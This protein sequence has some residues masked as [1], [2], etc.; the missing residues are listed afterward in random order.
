[1]FWAAGVGACL[2]ALSF[3]AEGIDARLLTSERRELQ[4]EGKVIV[5]L[6]QNLHYSTRQFH[7]I[8]AK[9]IV[10]QFARRNDPERL[11]FSAEDMAFLQRRFG[12]S[13]KTVYLLKG[14]VQPA[15]EMFDLYRE[16]ARGRLAW[17]KAWLEDEIDLT[18]DE[19]Y[20]AR[21]PESAP[22]SG[23]ELDR[24][25]ELRLKRAVVDEVA[26]GLSLAE[27]VAEVRRGYERWVE[28]LEEMSA[29]EAREAFWEALIG[30]FDPHSGYFAPE[31]A[32]EFQITM[33]GAVA[34]AGLDVWMD[35]GVC[36]VSSILAGGAAERDGSIEPGDEIVA[37]AEEGGEWTETRKKRVSAVVARLRGKPGTAVRVA[38]RKNGDEE[39]REVTLVRSEVV[40]PEQRA[41]GAVFEVPGADGV[42][43]K[44]GWIELPEFY[45]SGVDSADSSAT[46]DVR[47]LLEQMKA[48]GVAGVVLDLRRNPGGA[49][50][51]ATALVGLFVGG[52]PVF[53]TK[54]MEGK[55][56]VHRGAEAEPVY[57]GPLVVAVSQQ[58]ASA[59]EIVAGALQ[60]HRRAVIVGS[61]TTFGKGT[62]QSYIDLN[63]NPVRGNGS[64][65]WGML[66]VTGQRFYFPDGR[67][68]QARGAEAD[69]VFPF[70]VEDEE[71]VEAK[72]PLALPA[73]EVAGVEDGRVEGTFAA[74]DAALIERMNAKVAERAATLEE[75]ELRRRYAEMVERWREQK[76]ISVQLERRRKERAEYEAERVAVW[77]RARELEMSEGYRAE[78]LTIDAV[79]QVEA[80]HRTLARERLREGAD[81]RAGWLAGN[82][83]FVEGDDGV[84]RE[85]RLDRMGFRAY[86][87]EAAVLA[88][89]YAAAT[90]RGM[91]ESA[92]AD[93]LRGLERVE[94]FSEA[95]VIES[96]RRGS[97]DA[98][99][100]EV[101]RGAEAVLRKLTEIDRGLLP[102]R[103]M[104]DVGLRESLRL[105]AEWA[106]EADG[107]GAPTSATGF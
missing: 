95:A 48:R 26:G 21:E 80:A 28:A 67:S 84:V 51:E 4:R 65:K 40:L 62:A 7:E 87:G 42:T 32:E 101:R 8:S 52:G 91:T 97:E 61:K 16:R 73:D 70:A 36:R 25:W 45:A 41:R 29:V 88:A 79:R 27:A 13:L 66:R 94:G 50:T 76:E 46:R 98:D 104:L 58:S 55:R 77:R 5:E 78:A 38:Y 90:G 103:T 96:F 22:L 15:F 63:A 34:G 57:G 75:W 30:M 3:G 86:V 35:E 17:I 43:R 60:Y 1:M 74:V 82:R 23:A 20:R 56:E 14:D 93:V 99:T 44:I 85:V 59:S 6:L 100:A 37:L 9:D 81:A 69:V 11:I 68:P 2:S 92:M 71:K 47:E 33:K 107:A 53:L 18:A 105:T 39:R 49:M 31:R 12:R 83:F 10:E 106:A 24:A 19:F 102:G 89:E 54:G 72:L 64:I